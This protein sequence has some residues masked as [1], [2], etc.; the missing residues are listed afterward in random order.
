MG[1]LRRFKS[2][3]ALM[4]LAA[5]GLLVFACKDD[6]V[7]G[8]PFDPSHPITISSIVPDSGGIATPIVIKG[9]NF[10]TDKSRVQV[11]F[12]DRE[13][14]VVNAVD[15]FI[16]AMVPRCPGGETQI[17]VV[18][19]STYEATLEGHTFNYIV[20]A[21][22]TS[23]ATDYTPDMSTMLAVATDD[24]ENLAICEGYSV[25]LYSGE[26][27]QMATI[28]SDMY[29]AQDVCFS[30]DKRHLYI[31]PMDPMDALL[32]ILDKEQ[33]WKRQVVFATDE[34][35]NDLYYSY[36]LSV[37]SD[38]TI[39]I[40]GV[41]AS[42]GLVYSI[43][44]ET[45]V[46]TKLGDIALETGHSLAYNPSDGYLYLGVD[47]MN[48]IIRFPAKEGL[49]QTDVETVIG[50]GSQLI[51]TGSISGTVN[52]MDFDQDNNLYVTVVN[53]DDW[54]AYVYQLNMETREAIALTGGRIDEAGVDGTLAQARFYW[55]TDLTVN[56]EGFIYVLEYRKSTHELITPVNR[57][58]CIAIQ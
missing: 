35:M 20:S 45:R 55:P 14:V 31:L 42:G 57:L 26:D 8:K 24:N 46:A 54:E 38:G 2:F 34:I 28:Y 11:F 39:Y 58:R 19:D 41:G 49:T 25:S 30:A 51:E 13:A 16:Y 18:V 17:K 7:G 43:D 44:P 52:G 40:Y 53:E 32:V 50:S 21:R 48:E 10:G 15:E 23:V 6:E 33:N 12:D 1:K 4:Y 27:N 22:V 37:G 3:A 56:T 29:Y 5:I 36:S 47:D 9:N